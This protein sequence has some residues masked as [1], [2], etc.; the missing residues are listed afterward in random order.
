[1]SR[2]YK[3]MILCLLLAGTMLMGTT[4]Y[5]GETNHMESVNIYNAY[6]SE[7]RAD[8]NRRAG[9][10]SRRDK[11]NVRRGA[12]RRENASSRRNERR[13]NRSENRGNCFIHQLICFH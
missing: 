8:N 6:Q 9:R 11:E 2:L 1:M 12:E 10:E 4:A 3:T 5:A 13:A 7:R